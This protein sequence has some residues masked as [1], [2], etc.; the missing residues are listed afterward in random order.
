MDA[1][2]A[3]RSRVNSLRRLRPAA[4]GCDSVYGTY[5]AYGPTRNLPHLLRWLAE[6][7]ANPPP[8]PQTR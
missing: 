1:A 5:L 4:V 3:P 7:N 8:C 2:T 6:V